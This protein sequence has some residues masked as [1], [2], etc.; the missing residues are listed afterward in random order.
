MKVYFTLNGVPKMILQ[1]ENKLEE[2]YL[3]ELYKTPVEFSHRDNIQVGD[4]LVV[5]AGILEPIKSNK[6]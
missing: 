2:L 3:Q 1:P 4:H 6:I 5:N